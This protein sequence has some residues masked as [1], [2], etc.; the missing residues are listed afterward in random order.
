MKEEFLDH[1]ISAI[2]LTTAL[3]WNSAIQNV[4]EKNERLQTMGPFLYSVIL[5][6]LGAL[7]I[8]MLKLG[9]KEDVTK[10]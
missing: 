9:K 8:T 5:T 3:A 7:L 10:I 4:L 2:T 6:I 1:I